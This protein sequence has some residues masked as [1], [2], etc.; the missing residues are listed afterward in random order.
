MGLGKAMAKRKLRQGI[1][2]SIRR[3]SDKAVCWILDPRF[4]L[5]EALIRDR[6]RRLHQGLAV[7]HGGLALCIPRRFRVGLNPVFDKAEILAVK[8]SDETEAA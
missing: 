4:P 1:G 8:A 2:R 5:P 6:R 7:K 3:A